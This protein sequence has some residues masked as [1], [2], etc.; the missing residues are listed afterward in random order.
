MAG[1][2]HVAFKSPN[3]EIQDS[4]ACLTRAGLTAAFQLCRDGT[5]RMET[6]QNMSGIQLTVYSCAI[7]VEGCEVSQSFETTAY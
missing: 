2:A 6:S 4:M 3:V 1:L 5:R 7:A